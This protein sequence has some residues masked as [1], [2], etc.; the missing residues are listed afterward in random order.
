MAVPVGLAGGRETVEL[1]LTDE[2]G[3]RLEEAGREEMV[4]EVGPEDRA[5][6]QKA[7]SLSLR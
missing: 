6:I 7:K 5:L 3:G 2:E 1:G 4:E